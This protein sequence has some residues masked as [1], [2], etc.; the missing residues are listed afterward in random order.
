MAGFLVPCWQT[1][2]QDQRGV[3]ATLRYR[4]QVTAGIVGVS[5]ITPYFKM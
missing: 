1:A 3:V 4:V 2:G 5:G